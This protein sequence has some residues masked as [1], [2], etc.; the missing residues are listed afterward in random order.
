MAREKFRRISI[1]LF[2][3]CALGACTVQTAKID[4]AVAKASDTLYDNCNLLQTA[5]FVARTLSDDK[6]V[7]TAESAI[8]LYCSSARVADTATAI[9]RTAELYALIRASK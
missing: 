2:I 5:A 8:T 9:R 4:A 6:K 3:G 1:A 7:A